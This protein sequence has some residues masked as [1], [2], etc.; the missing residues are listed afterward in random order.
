MAQAFRQI[1][2]E[3]MAL[4]TLVPTKMDE[5][6]C[7]K[8]RRRSSKPAYFS[9]TWPLK[10]R[11]GGHLMGQTVSRWRSGFMSDQKS[12]IQLLKWLLEVWLSCVLI[13]SIILISFSHSSLSPFFMGSIISSALPPSQQ[14]ELTRSRWLVELAKSLRGYSWEKKVEVETETNEPGWRKGDCCD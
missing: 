5:Y 10:I 7:M 14:S 8:N 3:A 4:H 6:S 9:T 1:S 11:P 13:D 12:Y 2:L